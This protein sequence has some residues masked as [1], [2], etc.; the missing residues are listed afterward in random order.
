MGT[1]FLQLDSTLPSF[2]MTCS[3]ATG[4]TNAVLENA[5][6]VWQGPSNRAIAFNASVT[7]EFYAAFGSSL[8]TVSSTGGHRQFLGGEDYVVPMDPAWSYISL[9]TTS[10]G[11]GQV[12]SVTLGR[13]V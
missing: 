5:D 1:L 8:V 9:A 13:L 10:T 7:S 11:A 6:R 2:I 4:S 12:V 3:T